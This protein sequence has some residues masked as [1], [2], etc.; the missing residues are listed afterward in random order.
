MW[1]RAIREDFEEMQ[2]FMPASLREYVVRVPRLE[3][4]VESVEALTEKEREELVELGKF[5]EYLA[6]ELERA[7]AARK[8]QKQGGV[9]W[10]G[11]DEGVRAISGSATVLGPESTPR[12]G[13][14]AYK[15]ASQWLAAVCV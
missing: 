4:K 7:Q 9:V 12:L 5:N 6:E 13:L 2:C 10:V 15:Q 1:R 8:V 14:Q 3:S 11:D